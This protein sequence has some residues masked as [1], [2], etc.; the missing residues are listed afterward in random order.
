MLARPLF[1]L[2]VLRTSGFILNRIG[3]FVGFMGQANCGRRGAL[4]VGSLF[5]VMGKT[6]V[7][8][9]GKAGDLMQSI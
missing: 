9:K 8:L 7:L 6:L 1:F 3:S 5:Y 2:A 4:I